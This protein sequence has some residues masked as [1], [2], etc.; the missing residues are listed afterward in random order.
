MA[1]TVPTHPLVVGLKLW[2]PRWFDGVA[3]VVGSIAPDLAYALDGSGLPVWKVSHGLRG[4]V[5]WCV[6]VTL[7]LSWLIRWAAP[8]VASHL[9]RAGPLALRDYGVLGRSRHP[10]WVACWSAVAGA[11]SHLLLDFAEL[12]M[13]VVEP[14]MHVLGAAGLLALLVHVGRRRL[15][16]RWHGIGAVTPSRPVQF[17]AVATVVALLLAVPVPFL[18]GAALLHTTGVRLLLAVGAGLLVAAAWH[19]HIIAAVPTRRGRLAWR[20]FRGR[21][22]RVS[23]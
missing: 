15:L 21:R 11:V 8:V 22:R 5:F 17:W 2:R 14:V 9:P 7:V 3:L 1:L 4:F 6:P 12:Q 19:R 13:P 18:P 16:V 10:W 23:C 20:R